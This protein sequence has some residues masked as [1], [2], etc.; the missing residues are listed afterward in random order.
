M[1][2]MQLIQVTPH[3]AELTGTG[4]IWVLPGTDATCNSIADS[5][6]LSRVWEEFWHVAK[7]E[8]RDQG[9][10]ED[11]WGMLCDLVGGVGHLTG[12]LELS[13]EFFMKRI[14]M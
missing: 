12:E 11:L 4:I 5:P 6:N 7:D 3:T 2:R 8:K 13:K 9:R 1:G 14:C 10:A